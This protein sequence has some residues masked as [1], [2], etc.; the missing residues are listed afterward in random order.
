MAFSKWVSL[1]FIFQLFW[2]MPISSDSSLSSKDLA[3]IPL[4]FLN[5]ARKSEL[6]DWMIGIRRK[7]HENAELRLEEFE[8]SALIR[9]ELDKMGIPYKHPV[10]VTGIVGF[11]GTGGPPFVAIAAGMDALPMQVLLN[12]ENFVGS[13]FVCSV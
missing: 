12:F 8:T 10:A 13:I 7:I 2:P 5:L 11:I 9:A 4:N 1:I 6:A 3:E